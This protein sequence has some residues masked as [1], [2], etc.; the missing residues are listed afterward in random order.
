LKWQ[1]GYTAV[2]WARQRM[3]E[4]NARRC[5]Q[6]SVALARRFLVD[7]WRIRTG[8]TTCAQLG[9]IMPGHG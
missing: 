9:L 7:W 3:R 2:L 1:T 4:A 8:R 6:I 5:R